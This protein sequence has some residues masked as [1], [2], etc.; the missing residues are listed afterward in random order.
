LTSTIEDVIALR[1]ITKPLVALWSVGDARAYGYLQWLEDRP[2]LTLFIEVEGEATFDF[3]NATIPILEETKPPLQPIISGAHPK[4]GLVTLENC[5]RSRIQVG[6]SLQNP[7]QAIYEL[8]FLPAA[9]WVGAKKHSVDGQIVSVVASD[10]RLVGFFG[11]PGLKTYSRFET[12]AKAAFDALEKPTVIWA[13]HGPVQT[14]IQLG[15]TGWQLSLNTGTLESA[16]ATIGHTV[17][18]TVDITLRSPNPSRISEASQILIQIEEFLSTFSLEAFTFQFARYQTAATEDIT[19]VWRLGEDR[20]VFKPPMRHQILVDLRNPITLEALCKKWFLPTPTV[21]LSRWL[22]V[23]A[24]RETEDGLARFVSVAQAFEVL[25]RELGPQGGLPK[26]RLAEAVKRIEQALVGTFDDDF[27]ARVKTLVQSS[28]K[29]SFRAVLQHMLAEVVDKYSV[30][31]N[32]EQFCKEVSD[33]RNAVVHMSNNDRGK[34]NNAFSVIHK[35][36]F[37]L[38]FWYAVCQAGQMELTIPDIAEFLRNNRKAR[39]GLPNESL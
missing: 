25:G 9:V 18:S 4:F 27:I 15:E 29:S 33:T 38:C 26:E 2:V 3:E 7:G 34:L 28:N 20:S 8:E 23:R 10:T 32:I 36:S 37:K 39:A 5:A 31:E 1:S 24:L 11:S 35:L 30:G 12:H 22:F 16:S 13:V 17:K 21:R 19:L 6:E 14:N